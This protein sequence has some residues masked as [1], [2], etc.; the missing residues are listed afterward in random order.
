[1]NNGPSSQGLI[2]NG[3]TSR[4]NNVQGI[5]SGM[6]SQ[7]MQNT[8]MRQDSSI[9]FTRIESPSLQMQDT[10]S[11]HN[12]FDRTNPDDIISNDVHGVRQNNKSQ[13]STHSYVSNNAQ[14]QR[15]IGNPIGGN[16]YIG[17]INKDPVTDHYSSHNARI[18]VNN[19]TVRHGSSINVRDSLRDAKRPSQFDQPFQNVRDSS[20]L[21][22]VPPQNVIPNN[23]NHHRPSG[24]NNT[25]GLQSNISTNGPQIP[26]S[27][28]Q[29]N[30]NT[31][32]FLYEPKTHWNT[33]TEYNQSTN[34]QPIPNPT[35]Q[36]S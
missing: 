30:F 31:G 5:G 28:E 18:D 20:D 33:N 6:N 14:E 29:I 32:E 10:G 9:L 13:F 19:P 2:D 36:P 11:N 4:Y 27:Y 26:A 25:S 1:M 34:A 21:R 17:N 12:Y 7:P 22:P 24:F 16:G 8:Q 23:Y 15:F 3:S 35:I